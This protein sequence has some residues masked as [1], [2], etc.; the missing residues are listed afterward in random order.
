MTKDVVFDLDQIKVIERL[1]AC[2]TKAGLINIDISD[3]QKLLDHGKKLIYKTAVIQKATKEDVEKSGLLCEE[4]HQAHKYLINVESGDNMTLEDLDTITNTIHNFEERSFLMFGSTY[5]KYKT[6][7][8]KVE[9]FII[10]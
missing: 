8:F 6:E 2:I 5:D 4:L 7:E 9:L 10:E 1:V 3:I